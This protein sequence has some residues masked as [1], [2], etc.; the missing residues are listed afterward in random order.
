MGKSAGLTAVLF[1]AASWGAFAQ[2]TADVVLKEKTVERAKLLLGEGRL[3]WE[4]QN[5][6]RA[7]EFHM[8]VLELP[9]PQ[10]IP[11]ERFQA[12]SVLNTVAKKGDDMLNEA[13]EFRSE[14][15]L[16]QA[17]YVLNEVMHQFTG[18]QA[19]RKAREQLIEIFKTAASGVALLWEQVNED[20]AAKRYYRAQE[21][22]RLLNSI[23]GHE[24]PES[25]K[26]N[27]LLSELRRQH[28]DAIIDE[29]FELY[30]LEGRGLYHREAFEEAY[31]CF[32]YLTSISQS[33]HDTG[34]AEGWKVLA[35]REMAKRGKRY[36]F[37]MA[38]DNIFRGVVLWRRDG[39]IALQVD[40]RGLIF[41]DTTQI[42]RQVALD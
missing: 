42:E 19:A 10:E 2:E 36:Q 23:V 32:D 33:R 6:P 12:I 29:V 39:V 9:E 24:S 11:N 17:R 15:E 40:E 14:G 35:V 13:A 3:A 8:R 31:R 22:L 38:D 37:M 1:V 18:T 30:S 5:F 16:S 34:H 21:H 20:L 27:S 25:G 28:S 4:E 26:I 41:L 7:I